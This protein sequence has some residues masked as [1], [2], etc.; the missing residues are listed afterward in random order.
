MSEVGILLLA[1]VVISP[2]IVAFSQTLLKV[3]AIRY[4]ERIWWR[5]YI[6]PIVICAYILFFS[7]TVIN[8]YLFSI[9]PLSLGNI[10]VAISYI[11]VVFSGRFI[12]GERLSSKQISGIA[13]T[14]AGMILYGVGM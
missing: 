6:N 9:F 4:G 7:V 13:L 2:L 8:V 1:L 10:M 11:G 3:G 12:F 5:Q 14:V